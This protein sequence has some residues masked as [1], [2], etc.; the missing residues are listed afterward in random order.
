[1]RADVSYISTLHKDKLSLFDLSWT[2]NLLQYTYYLSF[3]EVFV[4]PF[5]EAQA[6]IDKEREELNAG[7]ESF[8]PFWFL[9][10]DIEVI[11][12]MCISRRS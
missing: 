4:D 2:I 9:L 11:K 5:E 7:E 8:F 12:V 1:M 10:L 6:E 3:F